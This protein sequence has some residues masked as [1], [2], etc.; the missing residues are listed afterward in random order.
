MI[1]IIRVIQENDQQD[2]TANYNRKN[3]DNNYVN[4]YTNY[5]KKK[6]R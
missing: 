2:G 6:N 4:N 3:H 5:N 1:K